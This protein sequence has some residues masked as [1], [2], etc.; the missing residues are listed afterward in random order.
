MLVALLEQQRIVAAGAKKGP[1][2]YCPGCAQEVILRQGRK[3][4]HHFAHKPPV[5]CSWAMG[6]TKLH[7]RA[8]E[9]FYEFF[10][11]Q[12]RQVDIELPLA[13]RQ[14]RADVFV[15]GNNNQQVAFE[16]QHS[17]IGPTEIEQRTSL[18]F[19][20]GITLIWIPLF[21]PDKLDFERSKD[22]MIVKRYSP[23]PFERWIH[24]FNFGHIWYF[25]PE[26][27][28]LWHGKFEKSMIDVPVSEWY[29]SGGEHVSVGG[30]ERISK[31]WKKLM[32]C[33]PYPL[34]A[35]VFK[36]KRREESRFGTH[37]YPG[38]NILSIEK[39]PTR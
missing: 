12:G 10:K 28:H 36:I 19:Q 20:H 39:P 16:L 15:T 33:G 35:V 18:Y 11:G 22:G 3:V 38:G 23:K 6:E 37:W 7:L 8:K 5:S 34:E 32:L 13:A 26:N 2:Y 1:T 9:L 21:R 24:G 27:S 14:L 4:I 29:E 30:Y 25:D 31:R 17:S